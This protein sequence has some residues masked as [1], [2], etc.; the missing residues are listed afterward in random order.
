MHARR[1]IP[2]SLIVTTYNRADA[3]HLALMS[4]LGQRSMPDEVVVADDGS[5]ADTRAVIDAFRPICPVPL[6]HCWHEDIGFRLAAIRNRAIAAAKG[7][8]LVMIDG[9]IIMHR[10]F[11]GD[12]QRTARERQFVQ[13]S[14]VL[15]G[16]AATA[17]ALRD[18]NIHFT[19][20]SRGIVN[21]LNAI[22]S[23][24]LS[25]LLSFMDDSPLAVRGANLSFWKEDVLAV[26]GFNE[27][28][29]GWGREDS[30]FAVR[31]HNAGIARRHLKCGAVCYHLHHVEHTRAGL[32]ENDQI[33]A[34]TLERKLTWCANGVTKGEPARA[35]GMLETGG[36]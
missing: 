29:A 35:T 26:N 22:H 8:Y 34:R 10:D 17:R 11:V 2:T 5:N 23:D 36:C 13:G 15:L 7:E 19:C 21:R 32:A 9:D 33:L 3:L 12:H 30:E 1:T 4:V 24:A 6:V 25:A 18:Q 20:F 31:M 16:P 27:D 14:R 28:F